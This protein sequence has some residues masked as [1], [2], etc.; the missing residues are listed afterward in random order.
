MS[1]VTEI[2][3]EHLPH[4]L[5]QTPS[6]WASFNAACCHHR[7]HSHDDR[8]RGG[9]KFGEGFVYNCFNCKFSTG[10]SEGNKI[11]KKCM[12]APIISSIFNILNFHL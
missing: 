5:K 9:V 2:F 10:Y 7:G 6:G 3:K 8:Q 4:R 1:L 11:T 12:S